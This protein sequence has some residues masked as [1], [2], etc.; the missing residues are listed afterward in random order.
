MAEERHGVWTLFLPG[1]GVGANLVYFDLWNGSD[2]DITVSS[3]VAIKNGQT[4]VSGVV[5]VQLFLTRTTAVGTGGTSAVAEG[6]TLT[7][8]A[9]TKLQQRALPTGIS[10]RLAPSGG[11]TAGA[12][13][14]ER[15]M[16]TEETNAANYEG[17]EFLP[18]MM[19]VSQ[20]SG[21]RVV[22]GSVASVGMISFAVNFY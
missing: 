18:S 15:Q 10:A 5:A 6:S 2:Q 9:L 12:I 16:F 19:I 21:I 20:G 17:L 14:T 4:A 22:Q 11:A 3:V 7:V 8:P 1:V 13:I